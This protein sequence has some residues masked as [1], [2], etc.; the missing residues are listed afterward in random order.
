MMLT[1]GFYSCR[2]LCANIDWRELF[3][4]SRLG[5]VQRVLHRGQY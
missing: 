5:E 2:H 3:A 4:S 1:Y